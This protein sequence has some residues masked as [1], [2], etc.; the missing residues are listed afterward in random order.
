MS[1]LAHLQVRVAMIRVSL[2]MKKMADPSSM[3]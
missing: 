2:R 3:A 1:H